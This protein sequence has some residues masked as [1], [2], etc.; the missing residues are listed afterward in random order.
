MFR[1][2]LAALLAAVVIGSPAMAQRSP[3]PPPDEGEAIVEPPLPD[4]EED[5]TGPLPEMPDENIRDYGLPPRPDPDERSPVNDDWEA[6]QENYQDG[7]TSGD[8]TTPYTPPDTPS[9]PPAPVTPPAPA[10]GTE[11]Y[12]NSDCKYQQPCFGEAVALP[13]AGSSITSATNFISFTVP[14]LVARGSCPTN[15][16]VSIWAGMNYTGGRLWQAG[17]SMFAKYDASCNVTNY[18]YSPFYEDYPTQ[19]TPIFVPSFTALPGQ[20]VYITI[21]NSATRVAKAQFSNLTTGQSIIVSWGT[22]Y[23]MTNPIFRWTSESRLPPKFGALQ[24]CGVGTDQAGKMY[25]AGDVANANVQYWHMVNSSYSPS[26]WVPITNV[27]P[28]CFVMRAQ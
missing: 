16:T 12:Q 13:L 7:E 14:Y 27:T 22:N 1:T 28:G 2:L 26:S 21:W 25:R 5:E 23:D 9:A 4:V 17:I 3:Y 18:A 8:P 19:P 11:T 20:K 15:Q 6:A 10:P 24:V